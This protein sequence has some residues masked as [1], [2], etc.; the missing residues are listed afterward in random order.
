MPY[1]SD[2]IWFMTQFRRWGLLRD[3]PDY[4]EVAQRVQRLDLYGQAAEALGI[5]VP[6]LMRSSTLIDGRAWD[7]S[8]PVEYARSF[9]IHSLAG[10]ARAIAL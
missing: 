1:L 8:D 9:P 7:G 6:A 10:S 3:D 5:E 2:G 4:P